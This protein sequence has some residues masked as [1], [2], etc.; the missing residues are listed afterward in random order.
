MRFCLL[1]T[2]D[3]GCATVAGCTYAFSFWFFFSFSFCLSFSV[4]FI[5]WNECI[6]QYFI[7][8]CALQ[9]PCYRHHH[10][11]RFS[12]NPFTNIYYTIQRHK[13][14]ESLTI[15]Q[16][17]TYW[18]HLNPCTYRAAHV[19]PNVHTLLLQTNSHLGIES[20]REQ[21]QDRARA[22]KGK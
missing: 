4:L 17:L 11:R 13:F 19:H 15:V 16:A 18:C 3:A 7:S 22:R 1:F 12:S 8:K 20:R 10:H 2:T 6:F 14:H 9:T 21:D 5:A